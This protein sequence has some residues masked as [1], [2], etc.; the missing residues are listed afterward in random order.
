MS[1]ANRTPVITGGC[2]CGA[3]RYALYAL[4][5]EGYVCHCRMCQKAVG[6]P[7]FVVAPVKLADFAWTRGTPKVYRS[8]SIALR[9]F[10]GDCGTPLS[11]RG[12][13]SGSISITVATYDDPNLR[14]PTLQYD[15]DARIPWVD[16][17][18]ALPARH[19]TG[20]KP[21]VEAKLV[22]LQ[23]PDHDTPEG[24][25]PPAGANP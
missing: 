17:V 22:N 10:C 20:L 3:I 11:Y 12:D 14:P 18:N 16:H 7:L 5:A 9:D 25:R 24:W 21:E 1:T 23:H 2:Q 6:S 13:G 19:D 15:I 4:P 8:S